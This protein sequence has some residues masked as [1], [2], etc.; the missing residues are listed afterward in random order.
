MQQTVED[1]RRLMGQ[2][3][4]LSGEAQA[5]TGSLRSDTLPRVNTLAESMERSADRIGRLAT[6]LERRPSSVVWGRPGG[7]PG[8]GEPGFQ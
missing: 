3:N 5:A 8:P 2:V 7:R 1:A 6:E 4:Q